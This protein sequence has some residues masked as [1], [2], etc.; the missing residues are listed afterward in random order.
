MRLLGARNLKEVV[1]EMV[2]TSSLASHQGS[3]PED[4][5]YNVNCTPRIGHVPIAPSPPRTDQALKVAALRN[6]QAGAGN[7]MKTKL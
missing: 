2:D 7:S 6:A 4:R 5:L 1:P 3:V